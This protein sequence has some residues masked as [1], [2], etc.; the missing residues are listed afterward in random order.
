M[1]NIVDYAQEELRT[2][3]EMPFND[4]DSL[5]LSWLSYFRFPSC[6]PEVRSWSGVGLSSLFRAE[7]FEGMFGHTYDPQ[8][9]RRLFT[10]VVASPR[11][12]DVVARGYVEEMDRGEQKQFS[13]VTFSF[14]DDFSYVAF[15]GTDGTLVGWKEDFNMA[16]Q[17]P[18]PSQRSALDYLAKASSHT[19][20]RLFV[21]GHSKGGNLAVYASAMSP[22]AVKDRI[23]RI[24]SHDGPGF[25]GTV[26]ESGEFASV[27]GLVRKTV[28]QSSM[29]GM[30]L[31]QQEEYSIVES[32]RFSFW[33]H[34]PFSWV[35][36]GDGFHPYTTITPD[37]R[38]FNRTLNEWVKSL[39]REQR[40]MVVDTLYG[41]VDTDNANTFA[42]VKAN[43]PTILQAASKLDDSTKQFLF[44]MLKELGRLS[45]K[46]VP[47]LFRQGNR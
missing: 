23:V 4:V 1:K 10:A 32:S 7:L 22:C 37:A 27:S 46:N 35:V 25:L 38:F 45:F 19:N 20:G 30:L 15:R 21:G 3:D 41:L 33:Q 2:F 5:I 42:D 47:E 31:E 36:D 26:L 18:V 17:C 11:F 44:E 16:F 24:Y 9:S 29:I 40:E 6:V 14:G 8:G 28:P 34:D 39:S 43:I 12:R 13:A